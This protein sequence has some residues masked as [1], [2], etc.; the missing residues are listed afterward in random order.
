MLTH[1]TLDQLHDLG[2]HGMAKGFKDLGAHPETASLDHAAWLALLLDHETT[3]RRQKRFERLARVAKL[4]QAATVEDID[5][6]TARGLDRAMFLKLA[7]CDWIR[8]HPVRAADESIWL[9]LG[10][11]G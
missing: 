7:G 3:L 1:P 8:T 6:R 5:Y 10:G 2:L 9:Y 11:S 4:R